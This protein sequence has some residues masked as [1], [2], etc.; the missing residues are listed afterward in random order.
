MS[1]PARCV[2]PLVM[3]PFVLN[4]MAASSATTAGAAL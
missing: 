2:I 4:G 3:T 1:L